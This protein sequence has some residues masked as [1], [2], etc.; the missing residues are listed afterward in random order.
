[1][2]MMDLS[3]M[4]KILML[5]GAILFVA[6]VLLTLSVKIPFLGHLPGDIAIQRKGFGLYFPIVTC[7]LLSVVLSVLLNLFSRR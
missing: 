7:I 1:M 2:D 4:G 6:G 3:G 5:L